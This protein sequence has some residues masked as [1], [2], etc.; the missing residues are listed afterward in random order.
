[1]ALRPIKLGLLLV[2]VEVLLLL[3]ARL[4]GVAVVAGQMDLPG[5]HQFRLAQEALAAPQVAA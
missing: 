3:V 2:A 1:M 4:F 5:G